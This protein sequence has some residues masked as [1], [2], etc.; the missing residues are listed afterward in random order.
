MVFMP[1]PRQTGKTTLAQWIA[2]DYVNR[3]YVNWD[4]PA[5]RTRLIKPH[6]PIKRTSGEGR[7]LKYPAS[8]GR[9]GLP[10]EVTP[11]RDEAWCP[12]YL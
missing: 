6:P 4:I 10:E 9:C 3:L 8:W 2:A 12:L 5:D 11:W 7:K 1:G